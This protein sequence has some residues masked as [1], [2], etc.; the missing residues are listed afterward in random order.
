MDVDIAE[1]IIVNTPLT[2]TER[3]YI[4]DYIDDEVNH[5]NLRHVFQFDKAQAW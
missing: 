1:I 5:L 4:R 3:Q 2:D